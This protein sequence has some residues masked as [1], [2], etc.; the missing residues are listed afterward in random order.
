MT[1]TLIVPVLN[2]LR[3][4]KA[5]M[6]RLPP[7]D[8]ILI[9]DGGSTDGS[10]EWCLDQGYEIHCQRR[11]GLRAALCEA[12]NKV[13]GDVMV[14]FSPDGNSDP[15]RVA[16]LLA[17]MADHPEVDMTIVSRYLGTARSDDDTPLTRLANRLFTGAIN[18]LFGG[19]YTDALVI[20]RAYRRELPER[21]GLLEERSPAW[22]RQIGRYVSWE[23]MLSIRAARA[24]CRV[25]EIPGDEPPRVGHG[26]PGLFL[27]ESRIHHV[28]VGV[29]MA[30]LVLEEKM[31]RKE[32][33]NA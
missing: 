31:Q 29:A 27:P 26:R 1:S 25:G 18:R 33:K 17:Y 21:L 22:E 16:P 14:T 3:G 9:V 24:G 6:P 13:R 12:W 30:W 32:R 28:R 23:P 7:M 5:V 19:R 11:P 8:Q 2:E 10:P 4:L 20:F 15:A